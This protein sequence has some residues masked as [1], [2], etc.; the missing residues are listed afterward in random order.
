MAR[1]H[2]KVLVVDDD[3][4]LREL[5]SLLLADVGFDVRTAH[6]GRDALSLTAEELPAVILLDMKMPGMNGWVFARE[7]RARYGRQV[8][9][10][11]LTAAENARKTA[12]EVDAEGWLGKPFEL[13]EV[14]RLVEANAR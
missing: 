9:I 12:E 3:A 7:L 5:L 4:D 11:V 2:K 1:E 8:P 6:D 10:V 14:V 13:D